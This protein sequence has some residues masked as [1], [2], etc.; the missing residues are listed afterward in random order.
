[1]GKWN[2]KLK[3]GPTIRRAVH[4][5]DPKEVLVSL[6]EGYDVLLRNEI[7]EEDDYDSWV[8]D[9]EVSMSNV[10]DLL[11]NIDDEDEDYDSYFYEDPTEEAEEEANYQLSEFY[12]L[13]DNIGVWVSLD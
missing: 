8:E 10:D 2:Y 6:M 9:L 12:D 13:C 1:M 5:G 11:D 7:I 4:D 3:C